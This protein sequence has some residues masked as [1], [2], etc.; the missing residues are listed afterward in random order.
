MSFLQLAVTTN[1]LPKEILILV[2]NL[3]LVDSFA[4]S[5]YYY[6]KDRGKL[7]EDQRAYVVINPDVTPAAQLSA[8]GA[9]S[10]GHT[11]NQ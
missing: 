7:V 8:S 10:A 9:A 2:A 5:D 4:H 3:W 1:E 11:D 6:Q